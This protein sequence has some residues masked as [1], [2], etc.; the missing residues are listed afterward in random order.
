MTEPFSIQNVID[1]TITWR[2]HHIKELTQAVPDS[3]GSDD[4]N[5][6][7]FDH[8]MT[9]LIRRCRKTSDL[10]KPLP[11]LKALQPAKTMPKSA[12]E[13]RAAPIRV[14]PI[15]APISA[16]FSESIQMVVLL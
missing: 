5:D 6:I 7:D 15:R 9:S 4:S 10:R 12:G 2:T 16:H 11:H 1:T 13:E 8:S 14:I 3:S